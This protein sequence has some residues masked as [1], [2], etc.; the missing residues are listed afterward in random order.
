MKKRLYNSFESKKLKRIQAVLITILS[1]VFV[2]LAGCNEAKYRRDTDKI[3]DNIIRQKQ[4]QTL[5]K[6]T[7]FGIERPSDILRRRLLIGQNLPIYSHASLGTDKLDPIEHWPEENYPAAVSGEKVI[8]TT[9]ANKPI[10]ISLVQALQ[11]G[12][13]NSFAY[14]E[15]KE[16]IFQKALD[17]E[18]ERDAFRGTFTGQVENLISTDTTS[19]DTETGVRNSGDFGV[20]QKLKSG[21]ELGASFAIDLVNLLTLGHA[22]SMGLFS[23]ATVSIPLMRGSGKHIVTEDLTQAD[24]DVIYAL[25]EFEQYKKE[26]AVEVANKYLSVLQQLDTIKNREADYRSRTAS[27]KR[28]RRLADAGRIQEIEV[29]QAVQNELRSRQGWITATQSYKRQLDSFKIFLG[30]PPDANIE[31]DP[32]ELELLAAPTKKLISQVEE[33]TETN[34][35]ITS[36]D[37]LVELLEPDYTNAGPYELEESLAIKL[38]FDNRLDLK[39]TAEKVYDAQRAVVVAADDL[40]AEVTL[41][42][43]VESGAR[44]TIS[45]AGSD[46]S[47]IRKDKG[48][49]SALLTIDLPFHRTQEAINYRNSYID[50]EQSVRDVQELEDNIKSEIRNRLRDLLEAREKMHIQA[51]S[52]YVAQKRVTSVNMFLDAGRAQTRDLL[53]AQDDLLDAQNSLTASV[54]DYRIAELNVQRDMGVLQVDEKGLWKEY[55]PGD[56]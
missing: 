40:R 17:L 26:F 6:K 32:K 28:S 55:S 14:Q 13:Y 41:F 21:A 50:L 39:A 15:K 46:D 54:I 5:G 29:D 34:V 10:V 30:L 20:S 31:L 42:G 48:V 4:L 51:K 33:E 1:S 22:S 47:H 24:R 23:D 37:Q 3:A 27:A 18:L 43:S 2:L 44:R 53:E 56:I 49:S 8:E 25:W 16:A 19:E 36:N 12:A 52:V 11:I 35:E 38:A 9:D 45:S 7:P